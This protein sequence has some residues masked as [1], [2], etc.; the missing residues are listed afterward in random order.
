MNEAIGRWLAAFV[1]TV[2]LPSLLLVFVLALVQEPIRLGSIYGRGEAYLM[3]AA[4]VGN[5]S[6]DFFS[7]IRPTNSVQRQVAGWFILNWLILSSG[8]FGVVSAAAITNQNYSDSVTSRLGIFILIASSVM[9]LAIAIA[10]DGQ[11]HGGGDGE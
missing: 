2:F 9:A 8:A 4:M 1:F 6:S 3:S 5:T 7:M 11:Q 10:A